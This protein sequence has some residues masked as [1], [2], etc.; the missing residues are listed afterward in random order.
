MRKLLIVAAAGLTVSFATSRANA[1]VD[2]TAYADAEGYM[3]CKR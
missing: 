3:M 1:Q 2:L